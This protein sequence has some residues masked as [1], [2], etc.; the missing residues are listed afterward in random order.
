MPDVT[1]PTCSERGKIPPSSV[2]ARIKSL[3]CG[4]RFKV[5]QPSAVV[6]PPL[7]RLRYTGNPPANAERQ[8]VAAEDPMESTKVTA[9]PKFAGIARLA[10]ILFL[11]IV[12]L[13]VF[14]QPDGRNRLADAGTASF[15]KATKYNKDGTSQGRLVSFDEHQQ[16]V[17]ESL[18]KG[19]QVWLFDDCRKDW[20]P[21][22]ATP[23]RNALCVVFAGQELAFVIE[24]QY[25]RP[26]SLAKVILDDEKGGN[27]VVETTG[28][29][30]ADGKSGRE[31]V[32]LELA[33]Q[34]AWRRCLGRPRLG[35]VHE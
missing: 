22:E 33:G 19:E 1:C 25:V 20:T 29:R 26:G 30:G 32:C 8:E 2:G 3:N 35:I 24:K 31:H 12:V 21:P 23:P 5:S 16:C 11:G 28:R 6:P 10:V 13:R 14:G 15:D 27:V 34:L 9:K 4:L 7:P 17:L 18:S